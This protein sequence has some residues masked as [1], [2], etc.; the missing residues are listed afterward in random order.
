M[1]SG[2]RKIL[3]FLLAVLLCVQLLPL[4]SLAAE[5]E[6]TVLTQTV[7]DED[8]LRNDVFY[9]AASSVSIE[10][11]GHRSYL[12]RVGRGGVGESGA[13]VHVRISDVTA[14][15]GEDYLVREYG[16]KDVPEESDGSP[17]LLELMEGAPFA[18]TGLGS[19]DELDALP[20]WEAEGSGLLQEGLQTAAD[21][22]DEASGLKEKYADGNP[23]AGAGGLD[24][25]ERA[26]AAFTGVNA[27]S[28]RLV[29]Q[30][31]VFRDL[32]A[33][34]DVLTSVV[35]GAD[36]VLRFA[37][38]ETSK[39]LELI[40]KNNRRGDGDRLFYLTLSEPE[41][42]TTVSAAG[43]CAVTIV[44]DE[45]QTPSVA[46]FSD[47]EYRHVPGEDTVTV[48]VT[49]TGAVN[50]TVSVIVRTTGEGTA[51]EGRDYPPVESAL[52]FPFGVTSL[53]LDI[54]VRTEY[55]SGGADFTL[56]LSPETGCTAGLDRAV[57]RLTGT[58]GTALP[59]S[60]EDGAALM[61]IADRN[62][63]SA[64]RLGDAVDISGPAAH[65]HEDNK[66]GGQDRWDSVTRRYELEWADN[67]FWF[68]RTG[69]V[70]AVWELTKE[71]GRC[72][73]AGA[74]VVWQRSGSHADIRVIFDGSDRLPD[75]YR[76]WKA[77]GN[78]SGSGQ[79]SYSSKANFG[80]ETINL[81]P[82]E[83][84]LRN[85]SA[86]DPHYLAVYNHGNC[87]DCNYLWIYGI[88]PIL[89][90][91]R[92][93]LK[94]AE[95]LRYLQADGS[96]AEDDGTATRA[97]IVNSGNQ[98]VCCLDDSVT[99]TQPSGANVQQYA[100]LA[101]LYILGSDGLPIVT[102]GRN[103]DASQHSIT[104]TLSR[105][106]LNRMELTMG[107]DEFRATI[108]EN[109]FAQGLISGCA[110]YS[111]LEI[112][113]GF[114]YIDSEVTLRN[115]YDFP[116]TMV[117]SGSACT[118]APGESRTLNYHLGDTLA[119]TEIRLTGDAAENHS[120][121][122]V[123]LQYKR[124]GAEAN[125]TSGTQSFSDG[126][127]ILLGAAA[128]DG[129]L[130]C[131]ELIVEPKLQKKDNR[132]VVRVRTDELARF[133]RG[134]SAGLLHQQGTANGEFTDFVAAD[135]NRTVNGRLYAIAAAAADGSVCVWRDGNTGGLYE[136]NTFYF[137][138]GGEPARNIIDLS[139]SPA[140][141]SVT[142]EG[143]L[144]YRN[145][146]LR[147]RGA[148]NASAVPA[149]G[150]VVAAGSASGSADENGFFRTGSITVTGDGTHRL[151]F[152]VS[153]N[154]N[155]L[156]Q[157]V[158]IPQGGGAADVTRYFSDGVSPVGSD[159]FY[160]LQ[161]SA[162]YPSSVSYAVE[163]NAYLPIV[164]GERVSV[165]LDIRPA[166]YRAVTAAGSGAEDELL[167][168]S[169]KA[170][171]LVVYDANGRLKGRYAARSFEFMEFYNCFSADLPVDFSAGSEDGGFAV[172]PGDRLYL[173]L[174]T[175]RLA[176]AGA[177]GEDYGYTYSDVF[178]GFT[179]V[180][181]D[182]FEAPV[183]QG[184]DSPIFIEY[185][186]LPL[187]GTAGMNLNFPYVSVGWERI[188]RGYRMYI[189]VSAAQIY[190]AVKGTHA[191]YLAGDDGVYWSD[192]FELG[193][194]FKSFGDGMKAAWKQVKGIGAGGVGTGSLG[195]P[196]W[197]FDLQL[198]AYFDFYLP[199]VVGPVGMAD[200]DTD[201]FLFAGVGFYAAASL[202]FKTAWYVVI[203]VVFIPAYIG[204][205][206]SGTVMGFLGA[207]AG[208][209]AAVS[210]EDARSRSVDFNSSI[211]SFT[212]SVQGSGSAS[213][214]MGVGLCGTLGI[215]AVGRVDLIGQ[216][217]PSELVPDTGAYI[218]LSAGITVD[219]FLFS[220]PLV[221][222]LKNTAFGSFEAYA[223]GVR[224]TTVPASGSLMSAEQADFR[225]RAAGGQDSVW[226]AGSAQ[227]Q[228]ALSPV[229]SQVLVED[230]YE[231]PDAR[232]LTL[233]DG[234]VFLAY[235]A[236]DGS[237]SAAQRTTLMLAACRDGV[238][239]DAV[240]VCEDDTGDF[241][242]SICE[243]KD[244]RVLVAWVSPDS[245]E[246]LAEETPAAEW[247]RR[248]E[249]FAAFA[250]V[251]P[252]GSVSVE[253]PE[254]LTTGTAEEY[255]DSSPTVVCDG[256]SGD[257]IVYYVKSGSA[258]E[259][260]AELANPY[261][262]DCV[263]CYL[264]Y[265]AEEDIDGDRVIPAGWL[266]NDYY[267]GEY[268]GE[269]PDTEEW[270]GQRF[271]NGPTFVDADGIVRDYAIPDFTAIAC[272]GLAIY[273]YTV[274]RDG[275]SDTD[276]DREL[277]L[278]VFNFAQHQTKYRVRLTDDEVSDAL[279]QFFRSR[280]AG[281]STDEENTHTKLFWQRDGKDIC[282]IDV[283]RL[284]KEGIDDR[285]S[286]LPH[287]EDRTD[288]AGRVHP[289]YIEPKYVGA[290][291]A[292]DGTSGMS[293]FRAAEDSRG[294]L[295]IV[296]T[297]SVTDEEGEAAAQIFA[298]G[299]Y[300]APDG[301]GNNAAWSRP[302]RLT[303]GSRSHDGLAATACGDG[304]LVLYNSRRQEL[305]L[306]GEE[307]FEGVAEYDPIVISD[308]KLEAALLEPCGAVE[309]E[310]VTVGAGD[311]LLLPGG[312]ETEI[313]VRVL[314]GG[315]TAAAGYELTLYAERDGAAVEVGRAEVSEPLPPTE[316]ADH[317]F[318]YV[319]PGDPEGL[320][321]R[322]VTRELSPD[323]A[324]YDESA[325]LCSEALE[326]RPDYRFDGPETEQ[327]EEGFLL[328]FTLTNDGN[329]P[330][331]ADDR[332]VLR[333]NGPFNLDLKFKEEERVLCE[334]G[335]GTLAVGE[336]R[337]YELPVT[338]SADML[339]KYGFLTASASVE[340]GGRRL[341]GMEETELSLSGPYLMSLKDVYLYEGYEAE[342][343]LSMELGELFG[344]T[345][346]SYAVE[347][348]S[349]AAVRNGR[350]VGLTPGSTTLYA[351]HE[352]SGASVSAELTVFPAPD[353]EPVIVP[354]AAEE[355]EPAEEP[356][357][358][359]TEQPTGEPE[360]PMR[361][362]EEFDDLRPDAWYAEAVAFVLAKGL[363]N[364]VSGTAFEPEGRMSRAMLV[365]VLY[366]L[367]GEPETGGGR[368]FDDVPEDSWYAEAVRWAASA[369]IV[370]GVSDTRF[371]PE[372][373][374]T[375]EQ[376]A[377]MLMRFAAPEEDSFTGREL[378]AFI[379]AGKSSGWA[380][381]ALCW[382][383][384]AGIL[385]GGGDGRLRPGETATRAQAAAM[386]MRFA[387][388]EDR[389]GNEGPPPALK[390]GNDDSEQ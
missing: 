188:D 179:F 360:T 187:L 149:S 27:D 156:V 120:A 303:S 316:T 319:L 7:Q 329:A 110:N 167:T 287:E 166:R 49:R 153:V 137:T 100:L 154:G 193:N 234:T 132:V 143:T 172:L 364:G 113:A 80:Y 227:L 46:A 259:N 367:A 300:S 208:L 333:L 136:G 308:L 8:I 34:A 262:N 266:K 131:R 216:Y 338:V 16:E 111:E 298:K 77:W 116:V 12:L 212:G 198:G 45:E 117:I 265:N 249:V 61:A 129:R 141:A 51:V 325:S 245:A 189:G 101:E 43:S 195:A 200:E 186:D 144:R 286:V 317:V 31:D 229:S 332:F 373:P 335:V 140:A 178:T 240:P 355:P 63:L 242:P 369:G 386:L 37:P 157:E 87:D 94:E 2:P 347:D 296:W 70:G 183:V 83:Q 257:A 150:A 252:D 58:E 290:S 115:P 60:G 155:Q 73:Y 105:E 88:R 250:S 376:L 145:Y 271:L 36:L 161:M 270:G 127:A 336:S 211:D 279:P 142:L 304:L 168:E 11:G 64:I 21:F 10:E 381:D 112:Q 163:E 385:Q 380:R 330:S 210:M 327:T 151:R 361:T 176:Q 230:A 297:E 104:W 299:L 122:G 353:P 135:A 85:G 124:S 294:N 54:P 92:L 267:S 165:R 310:S 203:P 74:Q 181:P 243:T 182:S 5:T 90:P 295:Y 39:Y 96:L 123:S 348:A 326:C 363:M 236:N 184:I 233:S 244:G 268:A 125:Y 272:N 232:L 219:L 103:R 253:Q 352:A 285:G 175:D 82:S 106:E 383:V 66:Y 173:R 362:S 337:E 197:S 293:D 205:D 375:R 384:S 390:G 196:Q 91:F 33:V 55:F 291:P 214:S 71:L 222:E 28:Q 247:L 158:P 204:I 328:R 26:R 301:T 18:Q 147:S 23:Y 223:N 169:P 275:V 342:P 389:P 86:V 118:L 146:N 278:Q 269:T 201:Q 228:G 323:G 76:D 192:L 281:E 50:T 174:T 238:W 321:F 263:I 370:K 99:V 40:P 9:L 377:L 309:P 314:N 340:N 378:S 343:P 1:K 379:D 324:Y 277:Y 13:S 251:E 217:A 69:T 107:D 345:E 350:L 374:V 199:T 78:G 349:I 331:G 209:D 254:R 20:D 138:A 283:T 256:I 206:M 358:E 320:V 75:R 312:S 276:G 365:T 126:E 25:V 194:P 334:A 292:G 346:V 388:S 387:G 307:R 14:K 44:D 67:S 41:G 170:A 32:Q 68:D 258:S 59:E 17:S 29:S 289:H 357:E 89:R 98:A 313:G 341:S 93:N 177:G 171:Q 35:P 237:K 241:Q 97:G 248:L 224:Q 339:R 15:Y 6:K 260:A 284:I 273:A 95:P 382:A 53:T 121:A 81:Y 119:L 38:G 4:R 221:F 220:I 22:L 218:G 24:P 152:L 185:D 180:A 359:P 311:S 159:I 128:A 246:G 133:D 109:P 288:E 235:I 215:R 354:G 356:A 302:Y 47:S 162:S 306:P 72:W 164:G 202:G 225:L 282:W 213:L 368:V 351:V 108:K 264:Y 19:P 322:A 148:G 274:D 372:L 318:K 114:R 366:R 371:A 56:S 280:Q 305:R 48:T 134:E 239:S 160:Q 65:G 102:L 226:T 261:I 79:M 191:S 190:D 30:G 207:A 130:A 84:S 255:Y 139:L 344:G 52:L 62:S 315:L 3:S 57:I 42:S 231:R